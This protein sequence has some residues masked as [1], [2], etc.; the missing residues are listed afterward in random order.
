[1]QKNSSDTKKIIVPNRKEIKILAKYK[2]TFRPF[3]EITHRLSGL[4]KLS[5]LK[6]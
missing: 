6:L 4:N 5:S 2:K 1:M 3:S